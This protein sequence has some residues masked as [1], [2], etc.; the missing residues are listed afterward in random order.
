MDTNMR[1]AGRNW[2]FCILLGTLLTGF[3]SGDGHQPVYRN[4]QDL[5]YYLDATGKERPVRTT[6]DWEQR[7]RHILVGMQAAMGALPGPGKR[8]PLDLKVL[9]EAKVGPLTRRKLTFAS[10]PGVRVPAYLYLP[11]GQNRRPAVLCLQ[12]TTRVG[13]DEPAGLAG[14]P[15]LHYALHLA[16]RGYVTLAPDYPS[17][18]E[19][20]YDFH[21]SKGY[22][23]GSMK[24]IWDNIRAV[25]LLQSLPEVDAKRIG[26]IGH[27][28][29]GHN[30]MFTAAFEPRLAVIVSSCGFTR[31]HKDDMPSWTGPRYM[32]RIAAI[33]KN[34][35]D[36]MPFDFP[37]V[38]A[39]FAPRPFL[40]CAA[41]R[42]DD[43]EM[44]GVRDCITLAQPIYALH[45]KKDNL[46]AYYPDSKHDFPADA[47]QRAYE[48]L[49]RH[50]IGSERPPAPRP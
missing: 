35:A 45:G 11:P 17:F 47:R 39:A 29:G 50:L 32:P 13:K 31:F 12:Q 15:N 16:R 23:S 41:T 25:D 42:D 19:Y 48:F 38:V 37:E 8:V 36:R 6:A 2:G 5:N 9:G 43:F 26:V 27:S 4:H 49:D 14:N 20:A 28:L 3:V 24:A 33:Y 7:R 34:N 30:A 22:M 40:A 10:E 21:P 44:S 1:M 18:G 46:C